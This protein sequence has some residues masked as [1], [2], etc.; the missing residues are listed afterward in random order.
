VQSCSGRRN[1]KRHAVCQR[2]HQ[3]TLGGHAAHVP[4]ATVP[5]GLDNVGPLVH[6]RDEL[7]DVVGAVGEIAG[8]CKAPSRSRARRLPQLAVFLAEPR[9]L[10]ALARGQA[11]AVMR[12][13]DGWSRREPPY[14]D[15]HAGA[16]EVTR[17]SDAT[18][19]GPRS[20]Y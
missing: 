13:R 1:S 3:R 16:L 2:R 8:P 4:A 9:Q 5:S 20:L 14:A 7:R 17:Q 10:F 6:A 19:S 11:G 12:G 18:D 15:L